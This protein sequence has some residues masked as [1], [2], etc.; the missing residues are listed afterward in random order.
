MTSPTN[1]EKNTYPFDPENAI[2]M[3]RLLSQDM[4]ITK[5]MKGPLSDQTDTSPFHNVLD[6][7]C[8]PGGWVLDVSRLLP[9]AQVM[10][11][12]VSSLMIEYGQAS[13][14]ARGLHNAHFKTMNIQ[15]PFSF[16]DNSFDLVNARY[17]VGVLTSK[18]WPPML[19]E[20]FR[21]CKPGGIIRL[22]ETEMPITN[23][24]AVEQITQLLL[25]AFSITGRNIGP[26]A[27]NFG[28]TTVLPRLLSNAGCDDVE[29]ASNS[30]DFSTG[31][32]AHDGFY[33]DYM[34]SFHL[35]KDFIVSLKLTTA[36]Q[37]D[38]IYEQM[39]REMVAD[40]F[41]AMNYNLTAWGRK[42]KA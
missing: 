33:Q 30:L 19:R 4:L 9:D 6:L 23:S 26:T 16:A 12:D 7:A 18:T 3:A 25:N 24:L 21:V 37:Y 35:G 17:L 13:A 41:C 40:D 34:A 27:R 2:E 31:T 8:G 36:E 20:A 14:K 5:A 42:P 29:Y 28:I 39:L 1:D 10:G 38:E 15:E 22:T 32:E 11:V